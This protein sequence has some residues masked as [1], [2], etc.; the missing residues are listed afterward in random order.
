MPPTIRGALVALIALAFAPLL[1]FGIF[2]VA[3]DYRDHRDAEAQAAAG[4]ARSVAAATEALVW[5]LVGVE[6]AVG[7]SFVG[8]GVTPSQIA[9]TL[10][11][12]VDAMPG[13]RDMSWIDPQG[14]VVASTEQSLVGKS[15][16][17][18][19]YFHEIAERGAEWRVSSLLHSIVDGRATVVVARGVRGPAGELVGIVAAAVEPDAVSRAL[20]DYGDGMT[21]ICDSTGTLVA[22]EP[23]RALE[24]SERRLPAG[25]PW[26][27]RAL[28][29]DEAAG[30]FSSF[31]NGE[32]RVGA[33]V[34]IPALGWA[35]H[36]SRPLEAAM[37]PVRRA[38]LVH[39]GVFLAVALGGL[40]GALFVGRRIARP[41]RALEWEAARLAHGG[42]PSPGVRGPVEVRRV[43]YAL[44]S[45][46]SAVASR[47][48]TV[49]AL[50]EE[51]ET[52]MQTVSHDLRTPLHV[53]VGHARLLQRQG[54]DPAVLR[55]ADAILAS[56]G[57][58]TR[59]IGDLVDAA[60][61][62]AGHLDLRLEP[63]DLVSFLGGWRD[64]VMGG[65]HVERVRLDVPGSVPAVL[66]DPG[67]LDQILVN[68]V[69]NALKY[70]IP[71]SEVRVTLTE[72][73]PAAAR[74][75]PNVL[76]LAVSDVGPGIPSDELPRLF[77]RYYRSKS[78]PHAEGLGLG[79]FITRKLVEA[80]G[81]RI[82]VQ[83]ELGKGSVFTVVIPVSGAP[84]ARPSSSAVA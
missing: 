61:L 9:R 35:A 22:V 77:E 68:L 7:A 72:A 41:L 70:S 2:E 29:G 66:A 78:A 4:V 38:A 55:R 6:Y 39:A 34:P 24:W 10:G 80:H 13:I 12:V 75:A 5:D 84:A 45:I 31:L 65:L 19:E 27:Q 1:I 42:E 32:R 26:V 54:Q 33:I 20:R 16:F 50:T 62:E 48:A 52:L 49:A 25:H 53:V 56:A 18:R 40:G 79:L 67:R 36:A 58:M 81:W 47:R 43:A 83:S 28:A 23:A 73:P 11:R 14:R 21:S 8:P 63:M 51:R 64:R 44:R 82:H 60:R 74:P 46:A 57:R 30:V 3:T 15:L 17:A 71:G 59:L 37:A 76:R 69:S